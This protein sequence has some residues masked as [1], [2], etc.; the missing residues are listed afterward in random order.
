[1]LLSELRR[2][3]RTQDVWRE[4]RRLQHEMDR[5]FSGKRLP[6]AREYPLINIWT[7]ENDVILTSEAPGI[8]HKDID[9]SVVGE[10]LTLSGSR[11][12]D[13]L[14]EGETYHR[15]E[16][17]HGRFNR[18]VQLPFR[19]TTDEVEAK[20]EKGVLR[21]TLPRVEEDKPKKIQIKTE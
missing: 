13:E 11:T 18:T 3:G 17:A 20:Y 2:I 16:R 1:M 6:F 9:I 5:L 12:I 4:M 7:S 8:D 21:I 19:V 15:Q 14:K 10:T